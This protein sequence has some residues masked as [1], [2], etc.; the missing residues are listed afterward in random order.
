MVTVISLIAPVAIAVAL[1]VVM[2]RLLGTRVQEPPVE[3]AMDS[4]VE[5]AMDLTREAPVAPPGT[6]SA[7]KEPQPV[8]A[9]RVA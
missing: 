1:T 2:R 6:A 8:P 7:A 3:R 5:R 4:P 9:R